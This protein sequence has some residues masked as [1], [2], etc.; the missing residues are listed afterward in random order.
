MMI[1]WLGLQVSKAWKIR[2]CAGLLFFLWVF[3]CCGC[4]MG[5]GSSDP[6]VLVPRAFGTTTFGVKEPVSRTKGSRLPPTCFV[7]VLFLLILP[8]L[9]SEL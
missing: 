3:C 1:S 5:E 6:T 8:S 2:K 9:L 7:T 4:G